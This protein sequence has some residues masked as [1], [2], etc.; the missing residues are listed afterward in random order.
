MNHVSTSKS[1]ATIPNTHETS[2]HT[3]RRKAAT[4]VRTDKVD[5][6]STTFGVPS[7][8]VRPTPEVRS[9]ELVGS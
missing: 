1:I 2:V 9:A 8:S 7:V 5:R 6:V 4:G 3:R